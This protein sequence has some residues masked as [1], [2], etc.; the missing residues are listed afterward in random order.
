MATQQAMRD[1][2]AKR[3]SKLGDEF[4]ECRP[5]FT[6]LGNECRQLIFIEL[7][8]H[9]GGMRVG[10]LVELVNL[11]RPTVSHHLKVLKDAGLVNMYEDGTF[12]FYHVSSNLEIWRSLAELAVRAEQTASQW[13][14]AFENGMKPPFRRKEE[15]RS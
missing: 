9:Y 7:L 3:L 5:I 6:A 10:E 2:S 8:K 4:S 1:S 15:V 14:I 11:S 13:T 12:N